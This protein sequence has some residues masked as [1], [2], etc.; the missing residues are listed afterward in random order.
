MKKSM[1]IALFLLCAALV[2]AKSP[3]PY[4]QDDPFV[5][6]WLRTRTVFA[7]QGINRE[8]SIRELR[9]FLE[10]TL[11]FHSGEVYPVLRREAPRLDALFAR[12]EQRIR[13][14]L[15]SIRSGAYPAD[16][17]QSIADI[18]ACMTDYLIIRMSFIDSLNASYIRMIFVLVAVMLLVTFLIAAFRVKLDDSAAKEAGMSRFAQATINA[19]EAERVALARELHDTLAQDLLSVKVETETLRNAVGR[20]DA[21]FGD[22]FARLVREE[23]ACIERIRD[24]CTQIR[25]PELD[26]LGL[27]SALSELC[28]SFQE[29][30]GISCRFLYLGVFGL[31]KEAEINCYRIVQEGLSNIRKHSGATAALVELKREEPGFLRILIEDNGCG[32][33]RRKLVSESRTSYGLKGMRERT[34]ILGGSISFSRRPGQGTRVLVRIPLTEIPSGQ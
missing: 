13:E 24:M 8:L 6:Q 21:S 16:C 30:S 11:L 31:E 32:I 10:Q 33:D 17:L 2:P 22:G 3:D 12:L 20:V 4:L 7:G 23:T 26:H 27:R 29:R 9:S 14:T 1:A 5:S 18:E 34:R 28:A 15:V 25:P 19:Q